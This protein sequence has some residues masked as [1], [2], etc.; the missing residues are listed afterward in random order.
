M[1]K[2]KPLI[3]FD[4][5]GIFNPI[6]KKEGEQAHLEGH[7][8]TI[9]KL[10]F[11]YGI[12]SDMPVNVLEHNINFFNELRNNTK[13]EIQWLTTWQKDTEMFPD[14]LHFLETSWVEGKEDP[15]R[16]NQTKET[17]TWWKLYTMQELVKEQPTRKILWVDDDIN[18]NPEAVKWVH[19]TDNVTALV[20]NY[21]YGLTDKDRN[22]IYNFIQ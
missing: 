12:F 19:A 10:P 16:F 1:E 2:L 13:I 14:S 21:L 18:D 11:G 7:T 20:P 17:R 6:S 3:L 5:D 4:F 9:M 22:F 8:Q 15:E